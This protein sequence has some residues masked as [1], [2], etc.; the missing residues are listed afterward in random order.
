AELVAAPL[1]GPGIEIRSAATGRVNLHAMGAG[2]LTVNRPAVDAINAVDPAITLATLAEVSRVEAGQMLA[3]VKIIPF[4]VADGFVE[5]A[6]AIASAGNVIAFHP[7]RAR[8]V[9]LV[10][11]MLPSLKQSVLDK[12]ARLTAERLERSGSAITS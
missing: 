11:T 5:R 1:A 8:K 10:Q 3:T 6:V 4:G 9:A 12:T 2:I 7:F